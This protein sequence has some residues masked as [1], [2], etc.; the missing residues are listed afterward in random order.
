MF[1]PEIVVS[2]PHEPNLSL[3]P[4]SDDADGIRSR[5]IDGLLEVAV[6]TQR[7]GLHHWHALSINCTGA[8]L[9]GSTQKWVLCTADDPPAVTDH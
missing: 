5:R 9:V 6:C 4:M 2:W 3:V 8:P 1:T 7:A